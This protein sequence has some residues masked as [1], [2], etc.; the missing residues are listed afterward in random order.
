MVV[1]TSGI[2]PYLFCITHNHSII[3]KNATLPTF[4]GFLTK[5]TFRRGNLDKVY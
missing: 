4:E 2:V 1:F 3:H 5:N